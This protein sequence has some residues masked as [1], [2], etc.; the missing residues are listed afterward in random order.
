M[1]ETLESL[2]RAPGQTLVNLFVPLREQVQGG[3][4][5]RRT[6]IAQLL[7]LPEAHL[8]CGVGFNPFA[9]RVRDLARFLGYADHDALL[10]ERNF[11][12]IHDRYRL[13]ALDEILA[14]YAALGTQLDATRGASDVAISRLN[15]LEA[16]VEE[17]INPILIGGYK[18]ELQAVYRH[19]LAP[20]AF[21]EARLGGDH[22]VLRALTG[23]GNLMLAQGLV[24][25]AR[26]LRHAGI[27][28]D[29]KLLALDE[30]FLTP[31]DVDSYLAER[32]R[33]DDASAL[34]EARVKGQAAANP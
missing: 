26:F 30:G 3:G 28:Q 9:S 33:A 32:P 12:F 23:E 13:L 10:A 27:S 22:R 7:G 24:S 31:A 20:L 11:L 14:L 25:P 17:T 19:R 4:A 34:R 5:A 1:A 6:R 29:E 2:L 18:L 16:Q 8:L 21:V 15:R